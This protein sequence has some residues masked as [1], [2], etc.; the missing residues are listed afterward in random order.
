MKN[1]LVTE[2]TRKTSVSI[3]KYYQDIIDREILTGRYSSVSQVFM[4]GLRLL[5]TESFEKEKKIKD[6][7]RSQNV[8][9]EKQRSKSN[10]ITKLTEKEIKLKSNGIARL[11]VK[12]GT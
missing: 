10:G 3:G 1:K 9:I 8:E 6:R 11:N 2:K 4:A 12:T 5:E 7:T